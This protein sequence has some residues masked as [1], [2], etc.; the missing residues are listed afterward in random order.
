[1]RHPMPQ[2]TSWWKWQ[3][4][5]WMVSFCECFENAMFAIL[6]FPGWSLS[7]AVVRSL[8]RNRVQFFFLLGKLTSSEDTSAYWGFRTSTVGI[9]LKKC[10]V[11]STT[12]CRWDVTNT[13]PAPMSASCNYLWAHV[14]IDLVLLVQGSKTS[15]LLSNFG[16]TQDK[17]WPVA[18]IGLTRNKSKQMKWMSPSEAIYLLKH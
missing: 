6:L 16:Q 18:L 10:R 1:M 17:A 15:F 11:K 8:H 9:T 4:V 12:F 14:D 13:G 3:L 7:A 2:G 5:C